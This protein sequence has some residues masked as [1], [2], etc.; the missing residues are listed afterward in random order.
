MT[1]PAVIET[2]VEVFIVRGNLEVD[3]KGRE[4]VRAERERPRLGLI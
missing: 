1:V 3:R 4:L 2:I